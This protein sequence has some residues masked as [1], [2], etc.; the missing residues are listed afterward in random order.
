M[1]Y[2]IWIFCDLLFLLSMFLLI[3]LCHS[4]MSEFL[5]LSTTDILWGLDNYL[6]WEVPLCIVGCLATS[7]VSTLAPQLWESQ[8]SPDIANCSLEDQIAPSSE[9][10]VYVTVYSW[11]SFSFTDIHCFIP[12]I[13]YFQFIH[14]SVDEICLFTSFCYYRPCC[15]EYICA[16]PNTCML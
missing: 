5:R 1:I 6:L 11:S 2:K 3:C 16:W 12:W 14:S 10:L 15:H 9:Q 7:L 8:M 4:S 13:W